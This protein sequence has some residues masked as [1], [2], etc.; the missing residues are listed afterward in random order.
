MNRKAIAPL[1]R[2]ACDSN[3]E[4]GIATTRKTIDYPRLG[5]AAC[6]TFADGPATFADFVRTTLSIAAKVHA[7]QTA[8]RS[9][10]PEP[11]DPLTPL[12]QARH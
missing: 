3:M 1:V 11:L 5:V 12:S 10:Q 6:E 8:T 4:E 2:A 9:N 7:M